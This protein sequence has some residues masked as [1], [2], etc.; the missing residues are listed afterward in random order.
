[1]NVEGLAEKIKLISR[2]Y[3]PE[4]EDG[5]GYHQEYSLKNIENVHLNSHLRGE[6]S[7]NNKASFVYLLGAIG[8]FIIFIACINFT[9]LATA[10]K[11]FMYDTQS[12]KKIFSDDNL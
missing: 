4:Q 10:H 2:R 7:A 8:V 6:I 12:A 1:M 9:N 11:S 5:S 3:I